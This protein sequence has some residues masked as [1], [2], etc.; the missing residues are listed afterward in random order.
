MSR[1]RSMIAPEAY[2]SVSDLVAMGPLSRNT[3]YRFIKTGALRAGRPGRK[4]AVKKSD[5]EKLLSKKVM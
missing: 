5:W 2:Y 1:K 3:I 4:L